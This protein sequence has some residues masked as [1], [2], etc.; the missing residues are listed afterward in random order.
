M[1]FLLSPA[2]SLDY[3]TP[4]PPDLPHT[5]PQFVPEASALIQVLREK[6]HQDIATLMS[7]SDPLAALNVARYQAFRPRFTASNSRQALLAFNGDVYEG[8]A[9][10]TLSPEDLQWAQD[11]LCILSGLYGMLRPL[12]R[13]QPYRLEMGTRLATDAGSNLYQYWGSRIAEHLNK[14]LR[15]D[16]TPVVV[17]LASQ[18]YFKVVDTKALKARVVECVFEDWK[19]GA[20]KII[21]FHAK[22]A[23]GLMAR[24]AV[25][26]RL[27]TPHALQGFDLEGYTFAPA[28][29]E[30]ERLVFRRKTHV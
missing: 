12:D 23:R 25:T 17:N 22:R 7:L 14:R 8:L 16:T 1:L 2:K 15:A 3:D 30:P 18:E 5:M 24:Y 13:M 28:A 9:A 27:A 21:S 29:S 20:Y 4:L 10:R 19:G 11:H 26:H 6:S